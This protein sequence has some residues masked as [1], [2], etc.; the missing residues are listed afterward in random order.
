M[1]N[2]LILLFL[3]IGL[4]ANAQVKK[5]NLRASGLTC[6]MCSKAVFK[7]LSDVPF[8]EKIQVDIQQSTYEVFF[9][10]GT[11]VNFD[12]L[13]KAVTDAGFSVNQLKVTSNFNGV[14]V[15]KGTKVELGNQTLQ[16]INAADQTLTGEKTF[17]LIDKSFVSAQQFK[18]YKLTV[19][20]A[21]ETG[22]TD[23]KRVYH[24][25]L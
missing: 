5:A 12:A 22:F 7:S 2:F 11:P 1:K 24:A 19:G 9:K 10:E 4:M 3:S 15:Q 16:F 20:K 21:Y 14:K 23:G 18:K 13:S 6:A 25:V 17:T 8:V